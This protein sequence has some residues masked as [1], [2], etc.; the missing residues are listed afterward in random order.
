MYD[1]KTNNIMTNKYNNNLGQ[2]ENYKYLGS[3]LNPK[4][5]NDEQLG[6]KDTKL[7]VAK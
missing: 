2:V 5:D 6:I 3:I 1:N 4:P 7:I